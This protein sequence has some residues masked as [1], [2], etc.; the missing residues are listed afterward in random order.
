MWELR[1]E[2]TSE[3]WTIL[4]VVLSKLEPAAITT[5]FCDVDLFHS[6]SNV[7]KISHWEKLEVIV[8][9]KN[10]KQVD[11][12]CSFLVKVE[13]VSE[14][15]RKSKIREDVDWNLEWRKNWTPITLR[16]GLHISPSWLPIPAHA[17]NTVRLDPGQAFGTGTHETTK[18]CLN[19]LDSFGFSERLKMIDYGCGS[20]ILSLVAA[21]LGCK[22]ITAT[23][24]DPQAL[25]ITKKNTIINSQQQVI[26]VDAP[27]NITM[28]KC[29]LLVANILLDALLSLNDVFSKLVR[30]HGFL[31]LS[32]VMTPQAEILVSTYG[33]EFVKQ[34]VKIL[35]DWCML[36][37]TKR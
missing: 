18:L 7:A 8:L 14:T 12:A 9:F 6:Y 27:E 28:E 31:V 15:L 22:Q 2:I 35:N 32:G 33:S 34:K 3:K 30:K 37:F 21:A 26:T 10:V 11:L 5:A 36:V 19:Y 24:S 17:A 1:F 29:D 4:E 16:S 13:G 23:D 25:E 20:G